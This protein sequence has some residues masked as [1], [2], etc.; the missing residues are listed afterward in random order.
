MTARERRLIL[1]FLGT[2]VAAGALIRFHA[3]GA[4]QLSVDELQYHFAAQSTARNAGPA[5]PS[6]VELG[7]GGVM[8][9][10]I[11]SSGKVLD[12]DEA[13]ARLPSAIIG[14]AAVVL[15]AAVVWLIAGPWAA[16]VATLMLAF[17]PEAVRQSRTA[18]LY[19]WQLLLG[20]VALG[21]GWLATSRAG[22][23][24]SSSPA[25]LL[26]R[27]TWTGV[28]LCALLLAGLA[29]LSAGTVFA[30]FAVW[31]IF[32][33]AA[34][35]WLAG[36]ATLKN[37]LAVQLVLAGMVALIAVVFLKPEVLGAV[38]DK[39]SSGP[40][41]QIV[42]VSGSPQ[43]GMFYLHAFAAQYAWAFTL[44]P[45][46]IFLVVRKRTW[47]TLYLLVWFLVPLAAHS[48]FIVRKEERLLLMAVPALFILAGLAL[49][50][51]KEILQRESASLTRDWFSTYR[52]AVAAATAITSIA[53]VWALLTLPAIVDAMRVP[54][55][56][57]HPSV[58]NWAALR[59]VLDSQR[60]ARNL[61]LGSVRPLVTLQYVGRGD[62]GLATELGAMS[63]DQAARVPT[64][65]FRTALAEPL[66][67]RSSGAVLTKSYRELRE[68]Y[69]PYGEVYIALDDADMRSGVLDQ[70]LRDAFSRDA[71]ELCGGRCGTLRLFRV[72]IG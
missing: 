21:A 18:G 48:L 27:W 55:T 3:L 69:A 17:Y 57:A 63:S 9:R 59:T 52:A 47:L 12:S 1:V 30:G 35:I 67:D 60:N 56:L 50:E 20:I 51:G 14:T 2:I 19:S 37:N 39:I 44:L 4:E 6:G 8:I 7:R 29:H 40:T 31:V 11:A 45:L 24:Q 72:K 25:D 68:A 61:P 34:A 65:R 23:R 64:S 38:R 41:D 5:L 42:R 26:R 13:A 28:A 46:M 58:Q 53:V 22:P 10:A 32:L 54:A 36:P 62:F 16:L 70:S 66:L 71:D 49:A 43:T 15:M 33:A